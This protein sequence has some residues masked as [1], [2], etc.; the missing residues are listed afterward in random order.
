MADILYDGR[1]VTELRHSGWDG[2]MRYVYVEVKTMEDAE[3]MLDKLAEELTKTGRVEWKP[4]QLKWFPNEHE[5]AW[6]EWT[7][8]D[9]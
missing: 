3:A 4:R 6:Y 8:V 1:P 9:A 5:G 7:V 2:P